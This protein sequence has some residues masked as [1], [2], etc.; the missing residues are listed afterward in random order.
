MSFILRKLKKKVI[1][2]AFIFFDTETKIAYE[3]KKRQRQELKLGVAEFFYRGKIEIVER[4]DF[5]DDKAFFKFVYGKAEEYKS[6]YVIAHNLAFDLAVSGILE[7]LR[8]SGFELKNIFFETGQV[9]LIMVKDEIKIFFLDSMNFFKNSIKELGRM[10]GKEKINIDF[11][12]CSDEELLIYCRR[13]VEILR[14][15]FLSL[16]KFLEDND[17][18]SFKITLAGLSFNIFRYKFMNRYIFINHSRYPSGREKEISEFEYKAYFGGRT[19]CFYLGEYDG[20]VHILDINSM[21]P[22]I[23]KT[24]R[25]P[26]KLRY[27]VYD[28]PIDPQYLY[29]LILDDSAVIVEAEIET[30]LP[31][32]AYRDQ[33][34]LIFPTGK[35]TTFLATESFCFAYRYGFIRR[36]KRALVYKSDLVFSDYVDYFWQLREKYKNEG[37]RVYEKL[38]KLLLNSLY[39]KF[40][41]KR[42]ETKIFPEEQFSH[43]FLEFTY[44]DK[45]ENEY[46]CIRILGK[47][48]G[49]RQLDEP[50]TNSFPALAIHVTDYGRMMLFNLMLK[51]GLENVFYVDT[52]SLFVNDQGLKNLYDEIGKE[53]GKLKLERSVSWIKI[54]GLKDYEF[55]GVRK[56]KGISYKAKKISDDVYI[57]QEFPSIKSVIKL[58]MS[59][60]IEIE[61]VEKRLNREYLK[62]I[63]EGNHV[64]PF[65]L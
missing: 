9:F 46:T 40:G 18:G 23:M 63:V 45:E 50:A 16:I 24:K 11:A 25:L 65:N 48:I 28:E 60:Y 4:I 29:D 17:L 5:Y 62:G 57:Q 27:Y 44:I 58:G 7:N 41:Q 56:I 19:E 12:S 36:V 32:F 59:K 51:A 43:N 34:R 14:E 15:S 38:C 33:D 61:N 42:Y 8:D 2:K 53:I 35:F 20:N 54:N 39:G 64:K 55:E 10:I 1:P 21:Y 22:Y 37:N 3:D 6:L 49:F 30:D 31:A 13:D 26:V 47:V 52:D